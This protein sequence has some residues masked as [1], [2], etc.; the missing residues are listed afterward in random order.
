TA[1]KSR[2]LRAR[3]HLKETMKELCQIQV[4]DTSHVCSHK[5]MN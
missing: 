1:F 3:K 2:L 4:D 5:K